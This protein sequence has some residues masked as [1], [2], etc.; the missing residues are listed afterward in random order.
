MTKRKTPG[1]RIAE[2][3]I[4]KML[5]YGGDFDCSQ[6]EYGARQITLLC[7]RAIRSAQAKAWDGGWGAV[8][9]SVSRVDNPYQRKAKR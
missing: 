7:D 6:R 2:Q 1:E 5:G 3:V 4:E 8:F 9:K